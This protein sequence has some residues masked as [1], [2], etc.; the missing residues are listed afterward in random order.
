VELVVGRGVRI[1]HGHLRAELQMGSDRFSKRFVFGH[2]CCIEGRQVQVDESAALLLGDRQPAVDIDEMGESELS[3]EPVGAA[4]RLC[5]ERGEV[6]D[7]VGLAG[8]EE[9]LEK[10]VGQYALVEERLEMV[11]GIL[12]SGVLI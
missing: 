4:E 1:L 5:G 7:V 6:V 8:T 9:R 3:G 12:A 2:V 10:R 11:K